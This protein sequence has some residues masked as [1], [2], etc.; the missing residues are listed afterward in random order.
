MTQ[1]LAIEEPTPGV[2][3]LTLDRPD[4]RNALDLA[5]VEALEAAFANFRAEPEWRVAILTGRGPAFCAGL[6]LRT[7]S[8]PDA[9]RHLVGELIRSVPYLGKPIIAAVNGPAYTGGLEFALACDFVLAS[10]Q[11][12]FADTHVK[13]GALAGSGMGSRL[14]DAVGVR[15]ARQMALSCQPIDAATALRVGIANE[16]ISPEQLLPRALE[17]AAAIAGHEPA[18]VATAKSVLDRGSEATLAEALAIEAEA[19]ARRKAHGDVAWTGR[20]A[21]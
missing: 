21:G 14:P 4:Q 2:M 20:P 9:P 19:L 12:R 13:I 17:V 1:V 3:L 7:F 11:A 15:F 6:D 16:V 5:L 18:L 10:T 8:V